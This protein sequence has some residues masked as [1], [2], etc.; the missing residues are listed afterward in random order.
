[1]PV[2][3]CQTK[4]VN[5]EFLL[6]QRPKQ[7]K[8][9][10][11]TDPQVILSTLLEEVHTAIKNLPYVSVPLPVFPYPPKNK[12]T[13]KQTNKQMKNKHKNRSDFQHQ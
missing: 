10:R 3:A 11:R 5:W 6:F 13:N 2:V 8:N 12:Q 7:S 1:M 4:R 9:R